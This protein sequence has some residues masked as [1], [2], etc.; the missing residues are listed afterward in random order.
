MSRRH[1]L[2]AYQTWSLRRPGLVGSFG[3][4]PG[5]PSTSDLQLCRARAVPQGHTL[6]KFYSLSDS[7]DKLQTTRSTSKPDDAQHVDTPLFLEDEVDDDTLPRR[8]EHRAANG[9]V[10]VVAVLRLARPRRELQYCHRFGERQQSCTWQRLDL[11]SRLGVDEYLVGHLQAQLVPE[12]APRFAASRRFARRSP[13]LSSLPH[14]PIR[15]RVCVSQRGGTAPPLKGLLELVKA[16]R[17]PRGVESVPVV[18]VEPWP[19]ILQEHGANFCR[20]RVGERR[21]YSYVSHAHNYIHRT[22]HTQE[23]ASSQ[24]RGR[25]RE[26]P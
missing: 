6:D 11:C 19:L 4:P 21:P 15:D 10:R 20:R 25:M 18:L 22:G 24:R 17:I 16:V 13:A 1:C 12:L 9:S 8:A 2:G 26:A 23:T 7:Y 3:C 14:P 5:I